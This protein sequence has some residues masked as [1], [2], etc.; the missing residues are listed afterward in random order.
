[1][2]PQQVAEAYADALFRLAF[3]CCHNRADAEDVVQDVFVKYLRHRGTFPDEASRRSWLMKVTVSICRDLFRAP[4]RRRCC[5][6][7]QIA[8]PAAGMPEENA[9]LEAVMRLPE[10]YRAAVHLYYY[11]DYT[12]AQIAKILG[13]SE[14]A[15]RMRLMRARQTLKAE[16]GGLWNDEES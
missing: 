15:V 6:L 10:K 5:A 2:D 7:E 16:L 12:A 11:E 4:W 9:L 13:I 3:S 14:P 1:M 8:E